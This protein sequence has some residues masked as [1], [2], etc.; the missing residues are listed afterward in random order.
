MTQDQQTAFYI[1]TNG[2]DAWSGTLAEPNAARTDGPFATLERA[3][4]AVRPLEG[5][6]TIWVRG[7][8]YPRNASFAL[9]AEDS[10]TP[11][12][13][14]TYRAYAGEQ[15]QFLGGC[16]VTNWQ[17]VTDPAILKRLDPAARAHVVQADLNALGIT[18]FGHLTRRGNSPMQ[19]A[20][21]ELFFNGER[22]TLARWPNAAGEQGTWTHIAALPSGE[23]LP[24]Q[25]SHVPERVGDG[26]VYEGDRPK[27]WASLEDIWAHGYWTWDW[28]DTYEKI[29]TLDTETRVARTEPPHHNYGY[30]QGQHFYWLNVLEELDS[31]GE[32]YLDR[33]TGLLYFWPPAPLEGSTATISLLEEPM[34]TCRDVSHVTLR[35]FTLECARGSGLVVIGGQQVTLA[36]CNLRNLGN[37]GAIIE[38]GTEHRVLGCEMAYLGDGG[39]SIEGG[40]RKTLTPGGHQVVSNHIHHYSRWSKCG[41]Y[42]VDMRGVGH[43]VAHNVIHDAPFEGIYL[44]GN[45]HV[46]EYNEIHHLALETGDVGAIHTGRDWTWRGNI[47]RYNYFHHLG[48]I[49]LGCRAVYLDDWGSGFLVYG[50]VFYDVQYAAFIGGGH[51]N[52][53]ANNIFVDCDRAV[54]LDA[55][56][57]DWA[58]Y[59][60]DGT[61]N[62][63]FETLEAMQPDQPPYSERYPLLRHVLDD[64][65]AIPHGNRVLRNV[66]HGRGVWMH[67]IDGLRPDALQPQDNLVEHDPRFVDREHGDFRLQEDSPAYALAFQPI[68]WERIG[69]LPDIDLP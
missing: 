22:M 68:P 28:A 35:G 63:L 43:R 11:Q 26:F 33:Q 46:I 59:Y 29:A 64:N 27:R 52:T 49:N 20:H 37:Y 48:G 53:V 61:Y 50:N 25:H 10:G 14:I 60:F 8:V 40:D 44:R 3:R 16:P 62:V 30:A 9:A 56:G 58:A 67:L 54:H 6:V 32:Y 15:V 24:R 45:D 12:A 2:D 17:P 41:K 65:P 47:I 51:D 34:I 7:G 31:P 66:C 36:D 4:D 5:G 21:L 18:D 1:A 57:L 39:I 69:L 23:R 55:R 42:A 13:P 19:P 38:G